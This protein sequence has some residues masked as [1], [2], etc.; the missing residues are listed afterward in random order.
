MERKKIL[1][2]DDEENFLKLVK[3]NLEKTGEYEVRVENKG[4]QGLAAAQAFKPGLI[5]LDI[6]MPDMDGGEVCFQIE[7]DENT[8]NIPIVFLTVI[9]TKKET[10][11]KGSIIGGH[12]FIAKTVSRDELIACIEE[13]I[14]K[15]R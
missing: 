7:N 1:I 5:L 2:I 14:R 3:L 9:V 4:A 13:N 11:S 6:V 12:P 15:P 10:G 8:K